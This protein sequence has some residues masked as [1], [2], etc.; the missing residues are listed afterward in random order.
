M[1]F[2]ETEHNR[3]T[4]GRFADKLGSAPELNL[5][6]DRATEIAAA[7]D[8]DTRIAETWNAYYDIRDQAAA[9][10]K[11]AT[12]TRKTLGQ[13]SATARERLIPRIDAQFKESDRLLEEAAPFRVEAEKLDKE[14]YKG[15]NRFFLV[16]HIHS[17]QYC[18]SF[19]PT[20]RVS[21]LPNVSGLTEAEAV[22]EHGATLCTICFPSAPTELTT[23][24]VDESVC[25]G[26]GSNL[27]R[28]KPHRVGYYSGN[29]GTCPECGGQ[30][31]LTS[32]RKLRKHKR[33]S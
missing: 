31:T 23:K 17:S 7:R 20:T 11:S 12:K 26:T 30:V 10:Y 25:P 24:P 28:E 22:K 15:W 18:S 4:V 16:E 2:N 27:D 3:D 19:R 5:A 21:W 6:T 33:E 14:L 9:L 32:S 13:Y 29:W 1:T 8:A